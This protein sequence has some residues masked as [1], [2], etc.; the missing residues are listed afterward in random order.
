MFPLNRP[1]VFVLLYITVITIGTVAGVFG[2]GSIWITAVGD[3]IAISLHLFWLFRMA[4]V[5]N[6][7]QATAGTPWRFRIVSAMLLFVFAVIIVAVSYTAIY[8]P[9]ETP[10]PGDPRPMLSV[11]AAVSFLVCLW[12]IA[13]ALCVAEARQPVPAHY[14]VG[15]F[16]LLFYLVIGAPFISRRLKALGVM[17]R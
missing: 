4:G 15:T 3:I 7:Q 11:M 17:A 9:G 1:I 10:A 2:G 14:I 8:G 16:L 6:V 13:R 5:L 12:V